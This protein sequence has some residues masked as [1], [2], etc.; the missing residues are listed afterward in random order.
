ML[1]PL[2]FAP[3]Q[4]LYPVGSYLD[5]RYQPLYVTKY[6]ER[7]TF[8]HVAPTVMVALL[9]TACAPFYFTSLPAPSTGAISIPLDNFVGRDMWY[10][11]VFN[12]EKIGFAHTLITPMPLPNIGSSRNHTCSCAFSALRSG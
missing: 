4:S 12:G 8:W 11:I 6:D 1:V 5:G 10:G 3:C 9:L 2:F 7:K